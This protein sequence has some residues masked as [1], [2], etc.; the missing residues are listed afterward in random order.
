MKK[1]ILF[2][3]LI[4]TILFLLLEFSLRIFNIITLQGFEKDLFYTEK[5]VVYHYPNVIKTIMGKKKSRATQTSKGERNNVRKDILKTMRRETP[6]IQSSLNKLDALSK[7]KRVMVTIANPNVKSE[8]NKPFIR[9]TAQEA[10]WK[11]PERYRMK[12]L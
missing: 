1:I 3:F 12:T 2:N 5:N 4:V 7:G 10:G 9:V 6:Y 11:K 8:S